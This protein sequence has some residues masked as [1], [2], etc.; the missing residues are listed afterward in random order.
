MMTLRQRVVRS[1]V[2][3]LLVRVGTHP[4]AVELH[5][6]LGGHGEVV[7]SGVTVLVVDPGL[8]SP[9]LVVSHMLNR[10]TGDAQVVEPGGD[11]HRLLPVGQPHIA[12]QVGLLDHETVG[13]H[14]IVVGGRN[15]QLARGFVVRMIDGGKPMSGLVGPVVA[16]E[17]PVAM[18]VGP[19]DEAG[20]RDAPVADPVLAALAR[21]G[22]RRQRKEQL[23]G[24]MRERHGAV[25]GRDLAHQHA[26]AVG[27]LVDQIQ[28]NPGDSV[29]QK[30]DVD[31]G[32]SYDL[33][34]LVA[35][36]QLERVVER[37]DGEVLGIGIRGAGFHPGTGQ[38]DQAHQQ[39]LHRSVVSSW[40]WN[41]ARPYEL[42]GSHPGIAGVHMQTPSRRRRADGAERLEEALGPRT[43]S[44]A[45]PTPSPSPASA[46]PPS[47]PRPPGAAWRRR[48]CRP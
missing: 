46:L 28:A 5:H 4:I 6:L 44:S 48:R 38:E 12:R 39:M 10:E 8:D 18:L 34:G 36:R 23:S 25:A 15:D 43:P 33:V 45:A 40:A 30:P 21:A 7:E 26:P 16:E 14:L 13:Y 20:V 17:G 35:Q 47:G 29:G 9:T 1:P 41:R 22:R 31:P 11:G 37:V 32:L 27:P 3:Q 2:T 24:P 19:D 42:E